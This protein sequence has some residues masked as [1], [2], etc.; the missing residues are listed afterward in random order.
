M[1]GPIQSTSVLLKPSFGRMW[2][3]CAV[4][5][6]F[7]EEF[8]LREDSLGTSQMYHPL[9]ARENCFL[10][11]YFADRYRV[12]TV[13]NGAVHRAPRCV[14][15]GPH[16]RR[17]EDLIWT[18]HL[19]LFTIRFTAVGFRALF[20]TPARAICDVAESAE[21]VL[22]ERVRELEERLATASDEALGSVAE[23][24]LLKQLLRHEGAMKGA[25][26]LRMVST[27][28]RRHGGNAVS[29]LAMQH[30]LSVRQV[31]RIFLEHV[32]MTPKVFGRLARLKTAM[33]LSAGPAMPDWAEVAIAAGYFDQS[34]MV[35]EY[36]ALNGATPVE[37][38]A[39]ERRAS[40]FRVRDA[41]GV[42]FVLSGAA[43]N[44]VA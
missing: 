38:R 8:S 15:V 3:P 18:G 11:F 41:G 28:R 44:L 33:R 20:G 37:F 31:E 39:L 9:P 6:P 22:G 32:G 16:T 21:A 1:A 10:Q 42:A 35:R 25:V 30:G 36:R 14:L 34:H 43:K 24:F 7:V 5:A 40:E 26:A 27:L 29:A 2:K 13:A 4:L 17:R 19:K 23:R 12:V